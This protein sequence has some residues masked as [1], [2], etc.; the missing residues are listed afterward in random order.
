MLDRHVRK[1]TK[2]YS[3][4]RA[5][6]LGTAVEGDLAKH[7]M[8]LES[9]GYGLTPHDVRKLVYDYAEANHITHSFNRDKQSASYDWL[10]AFMRRHPG[11]SLRKPEGLSVARAM[12]MNRY[13]V[14]TYFDTLQTVI[15]DHGFTAS[16]IYNVD[17]TGLTEVHKPRNII[18]GKGKKGIH[19]ITR[20]WHNDNSIMLRKCNRTLCSA[21]RDIQRCLTKHTTGEIGTSWDRSKD[22]QKWLDRF[23]IIPRL[24]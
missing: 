20:K 15:A 12:G 9:R 8:L 16:T 23:R 17:E 11:L 13:K 1:K 7:L 14:D 6:S 21:I 19:S 4:G 3:L 18:A 24:D 22:E 10:I 2:H 5:S